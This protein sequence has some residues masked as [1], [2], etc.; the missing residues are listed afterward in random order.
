M[1]KL[2]AENQSDVVVLSSLLQD[3]ILRVGEIKY[4]KKG[5]ALSLRLTRYAHEDGDAKR[6]LCGL[7]VDGVE[8]VNSKGIERDNSE[9]LAVLLSVSFEPALNISL[10][11]AG[12]LHFIFAG[13][14]EIVCDVECVDMTLADVSEPRPTKSQPLHPLSS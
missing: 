5:R 1:L 7:R 10:E 11:P 6:V 14:G 13:A 8:A 2:K 3:A 4:S 9:A 12:K